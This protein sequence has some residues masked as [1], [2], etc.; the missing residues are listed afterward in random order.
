MWA[1]I[2]LQ[3]AGGVAPSA[4]IEKPTYTYDYSDNEDDDDADESRAAPSKRQKKAPADI[5]ALN[6]QPESRHLACIYQK[7]L[8]FFIC[9][10]NSGE[11]YAPI[12]GRTLD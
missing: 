10:R 11:C 5:T 12:Q 3:G 8:M 9:R 6:I 7:F 1:T 4:S 2:L